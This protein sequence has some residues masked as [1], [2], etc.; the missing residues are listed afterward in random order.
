MNSI[1]LSKNEVQII[2]LLMDSEMSIT[3]ISLEMNK[4]LSWISR[5]VSH[6]EEM[7]I[8]EKK[9][10]GITRNIKISDNE[11]GNAISVLFRENKMLNVYE[12][13]PYTRIKILIQLLP[14]GSSIKEIIIQS[15]I[16]KSTVEKNIRKW[17]YMGIVYKSDEKYIIN[18]K[19]KNLKKFIMAIAKIKNQL[20]LKDNGINGL[21][22]WQWRNEFIFSVKEEIKNN[23]FIKCGLSRLKEI[24]YNIIHDNE[25][26]FFSPI[27][28]QINIEEIFLQSMIIDPNNPRIEILIKKS[29]DRK[30]VNVEFLLQQSVKYGLQGRIKEVIY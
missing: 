1:S 29:I 3:K 26:Y 20:I 14:P 15:N 27:T 22:I 28:D 30:E 16:S 19:Q 11:I 9:E 10:Y 17:K 7:R 18:P 21:I 13:L 2:K 4:S 6:L 5:C 12:I 8:V 23:L 25:Y 24:K